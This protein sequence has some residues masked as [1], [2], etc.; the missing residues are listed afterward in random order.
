MLAL[1]P[2]LLFASC[3][4]CVRHAAK[5]VT[6]MGLSA[7]EGASEA[8]NEH[9]EEVGRKAADALGQIAE[10]AG[11]SIERQLN[12]HAEYVAS[13]A[14]CTFVQSVEGLDAGLTAEYYDSIGH[15]EE[16]AEGVS[17]DLFGKIKSADVIDAYFIV[18]EP[19]SYHAEF[20][21]AATGEP[22]IMIKKADIESAGGGERS[23]VSFALNAGELA[24]FRASETVTVKVSKSTN[25]EPQ[26]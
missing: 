20:I 8:I 9:G 11:A 4:S 21:F 12:E 13:V 1:A 16:L 2:A 17:L 14:G 10:G 18:T 24:K 19:G 5:K 22:M 25:D 15:T 23:V 7:V 26:P 6:E 3:E